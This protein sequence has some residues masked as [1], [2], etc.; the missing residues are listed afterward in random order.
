MWWDVGVAG[1]RLPLPSKFIVMPWITL[2]YNIVKSFPEIELMDGEEEDVPFQEIT[3]PKEETLFHIGD[4][5]MIAQTLVCKKCDGDQFNV[6][7]ASYYTAIRCVK[8]EW[9]ICVHNG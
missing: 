2:N 3:K 5:D 7:R 8:C 9:E 1:W 4:G 6:G